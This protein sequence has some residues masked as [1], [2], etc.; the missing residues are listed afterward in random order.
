MRKIAF[1][2]RAFEAFNE[3]S[4]QDRKVYARIVEILKEHSEKSLFRP[5]QA[6]AVE[7]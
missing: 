7:A 2:P 5:R 1:L 4:V 6:G 3:W